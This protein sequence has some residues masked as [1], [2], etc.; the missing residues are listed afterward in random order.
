MHL[1]DPLRPKS[2][3][4]RP[5]HLS[6]GGKPIAAVPHFRIDLGEDFVE[7]SCWLL[8]AH[9]TG[10]EFHF[11]SQ[12]GN[13]LEG[14]LLDYHFDPELTLMQKFNYSGAWADREAPAWAAAPKV[15]LAM[16]GLKRTPT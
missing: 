15:T 11:Q 8:V 5:M 3:A 4:G 16:L 12:R 9:V 1:F 6:P 10:R 14:F 13:S 7:V 2:L